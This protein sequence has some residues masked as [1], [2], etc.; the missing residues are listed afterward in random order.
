MKPW[1]DGIGCLYMPCVDFLD[2]FLADVSIISTM[3]V[4]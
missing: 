2:M 3:V 1:H 4:D